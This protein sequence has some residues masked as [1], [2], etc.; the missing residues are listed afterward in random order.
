MKVPINKVEKYKWLAAEG[1]RYY[2]HV[3]DCNDCFRKPLD[4][5]KTGFRILMREVEA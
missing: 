2:R 4:P 5:P 1:N 3:L